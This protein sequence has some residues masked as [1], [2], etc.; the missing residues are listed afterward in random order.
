[1]ALDVTG[2][3]LFTMT[4]FGHH[5]AE[6]AAAHKAVFAFVGRFNDFLNAAVN[7]DFLIHEGLA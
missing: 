5:M 2:A 6:L 3:F 4:L 1:M 7:F